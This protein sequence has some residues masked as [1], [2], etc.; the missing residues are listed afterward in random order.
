PDHPV[1]E[2]VLCPKGLS[3]HE[4]IHVSTRARFP[5]S[6]SSRKARL[7]RIGWD[8]AVRTMA[9]RFRDVQSRYGN[10]SV[11]ILSTGQLV[12]EEFYALGKLAQLGLRTRNYDGNTT[13]CMATA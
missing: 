10:D 13:L 1:N 5:L 8:D 4:T 2:G 12:T 9:T 7:Q 3:E 11:G 6:R